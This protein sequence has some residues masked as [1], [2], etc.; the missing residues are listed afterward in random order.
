MIVFVDRSHKRERERKKERGGEGEG[1][2]PG[3]VT[4]RNGHSRRETETTNFLIVD[5]QAL[6]LLKINI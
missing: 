5:Y 1:E 3:R 6:E 2:E 4:W